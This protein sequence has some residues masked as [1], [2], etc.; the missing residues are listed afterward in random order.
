MM[1]LGGLDVEEVRMLSA[2]PEAAKLRPLGV[3]EYMTP[4]WMELVGLF[5]NNIEKL[6]SLLYGFQD[7]C[8]VAKVR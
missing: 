7:Y 2:V 5:N 3:E 4:R 6:N 1:T 8:V